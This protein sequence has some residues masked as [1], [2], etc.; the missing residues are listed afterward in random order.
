MQDLDHGLGGSP[1]IDPSRI[2]DKSV[3][4]VVLKPNS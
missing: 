3:I 4:I 1:R 2:M